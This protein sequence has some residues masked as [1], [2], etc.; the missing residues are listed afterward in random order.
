MIFLIDADEICAGS[1]MPL[2][3]SDRR[4]SHIYLNPSWV[5]LPYDQTLIA[6]KRNSS[7]R[8]SVEQILKSQLN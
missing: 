5:L 1:S 2:Q 8:L 6:T 4:H 7:L 3:Q